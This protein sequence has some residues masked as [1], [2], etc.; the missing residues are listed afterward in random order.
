MTSLGEA[1]IC[2]TW[3][4]RS[5]PAEALPMAKRNFER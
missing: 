1:S 2:Q 3:L 5:I 4:G